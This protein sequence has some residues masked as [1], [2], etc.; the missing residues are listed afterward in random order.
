LERGQ[1]SRHKDRD[2]D[3]ADAAHES[4]ELAHRCG[5]QLLAID[6]LLLL[7]DLGARRSKEL[8]A[9]RLAGAATAARERIGHRA[10]LLEHP[11]HL[12]A[13]IEQLSHDEPAAFAEGRTLDLDAAVT[14]AQRMRG[15][16][17]RPAFGWDS[18]TPTER[19][20]SE[21]A[22]GGATN[23]QIAEQLLVKPATV[24]THLTHVFAKLGV[25]NRTELAHAWTSRR[26]DA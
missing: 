11:G 7:V 6:V 22:A 1:W 20:V 9:A 12:D 23:A 4:L 26:S 17:G 16:R 24:K 14:Y 2:A 3:A 5:F 8:T 10:R 15:E 19:Q 13:L 21:L 18:L 25:A